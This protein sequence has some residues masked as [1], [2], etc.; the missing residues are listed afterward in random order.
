MRLLDFIKSK[1]LHDFARGEKDLSDF[2]NLKDILIL[3]KAD[4]TTID[5]FISEFIYKILE[6]HEIIKNLKGYKKYFIKVS[7]R[8]PE[9]ATAIEAY[10]IWK[11]TFFSK[12]ETPFDLPRQKYNSICP[13]DII[14]V[15]LECIN[16]YNSTMD[17]WS[18]FEGY[19]LSMLI[20][21]NKGEIWD[22][23]GEKVT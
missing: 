4:G 19:V 6:R 16:L 22:A 21:T 18:G 10:N 3:P 5:N 20:D 2:V 12:I 17:S 13:K 7:T 23:R 11:E 1:C 14:L 15:Q 9:R 8:I